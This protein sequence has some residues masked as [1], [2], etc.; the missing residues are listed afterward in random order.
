MTDSPAT[1]MLVAQTATDTAQPVTAENPA[2]AVTGTHTA[3]APMVFPPFDTSTFPSQILWLA[4]TFGLL[5]LILS[6]VAVPRLAGIGITRRD[7]IEGDLAEADKA[8]Q[9]TDKAIA[10][11]ETALAEARQ[12]AH[13]IAEE[14]RNGIRADL[15]AKRNGVETELA[16]K[17]SAAEADIQKAKTAAMSKVNEI[18]ADTAASVVQALSGPVSASDAQAAVASV[19]KE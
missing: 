6:R 9:A 3:E 12:K 17:V 5:Y 11:Y 7:K 19:V 1:F 16:A 4:I 13:A 14:T 15:D 8:R 10:D 18:A 2:L